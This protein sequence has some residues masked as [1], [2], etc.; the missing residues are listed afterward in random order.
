MTLDLTF[1][2]AVN[3]AQYQYVIAF[4]LPGTLVIPN[5]NTYLAIP[6]QSINQD[7]TSSTGGTEGLSY[8]Y[9]NFFSTWKDFILVANNTASLYAPVGGFP[10]SITDS[11]HNGYLAIASSQFGNTSFSDTKIHLEFDLLRLGLGATHMTL[12]VLTLDS[13]GSI[14]D[15][16]N[17]NRD[18]EALSNNQYG[19]TLSRLN[20]AIPAA[21]LKS[22]SLSFR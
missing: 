16:Q 9:R 17:F 11:L 15:A 21:T 7:R 6:G 10:T 5:A 18:M 1:M 8:F 3:S 4:A 20:V 14:I 22:W 13:N 12:A 2:G 19:D